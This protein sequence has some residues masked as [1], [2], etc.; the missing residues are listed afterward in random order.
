MSRTR[1]LLRLALLTSTCG[2]LSCGGARPGTPAA[3]TPE[4]SLV[5][6]DTMGATG[7]KPALPESGP[8]V[9]PE[10]QR[11]LKA[12]EAAAASGDVAAAR[13]HFEQAARA[14]GGAA[15]AHYNLGILAER[16]D[17]PADARRSYEAALSARPEFGP[18]VVAIAYQMLREGDK[19]SAMSYAEGRLAQSPQSNDLKNAVSRLRLLTGDIERAIRES[20]LVLRVD[21]KNVD[22]MKV[23]A[24]GYAKQNKHELA[25]AIL[26][27]AQALDASDPE[28][29]AK[30]A[31]SYQ[32]LDEKPK[33]RAALEAAVKLNG[34]GSAETYN[35][36]GVMYHEAGDFVG[37]ESM[38]VEALKRWPT[39]VAAQLN[40]GSAF[41]GQQRYA[42]AESAMKHALKLSRSSGDILF[43]LGILYLDGQFAEIDAVTRL[44]RAVEYFEKY[45]QAPGRPAGNDPV[46]QYVAEAN[47]RIEVEKK[48]AASQRQAP[49]APEP[50]GG[51]TP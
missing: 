43:N 28:I 41:K 46:D 2:L 39:M 37:A 5:S 8:K 17:R 48:K 50:G 31:R 14:D 38:F 34:G 20:T 12:G 27:N 7:I 42:E 47:K 13:G 32:A 35:D 4:A 45:K 16:E 30:V 6:P 25:I 19:G 40:L 22:A 11:D 18:A 1:T 26:R 21:E 29:F 9:S 3:N 51:D 49:K 23:L 44:E 10:A 15:E 33:A 24:A 36:L